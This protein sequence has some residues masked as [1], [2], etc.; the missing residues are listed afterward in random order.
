[1]G[2]CIQKIIRNSA[3]GMLAALFPAL[4]QAQPKPLPLPQGTCEGVLPNGLHY[5]L[6]QNDIPVSRIEFRLVLRTGSVQELD[7]ETGCAHFLEHVAFGGSR[8]FPDKSLQSYLETLGMKYGVDINAFTSQD[9]TIYLFAVPTDSQRKGVIDS[10]LLILRDWMDGLK[11]CPERVE[12]ERG[13]IL[14][15]L[16]GYDVGDPF[17]DLKIG[18]GIHARRLPLGTIGDIRRITPATLK[19]TTGMV[20]AGTGDN[21]GRGRL[22]HGGIGA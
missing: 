12:T 21:R 13:I 19:T 9:R 17:Y 5:I 6:R 18:E 7:R 4:L 1:M 15:E 2:E 10:A 20:C 8:H 14:E 16:R 3:A 11:I 22:R